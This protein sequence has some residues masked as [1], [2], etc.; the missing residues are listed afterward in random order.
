MNLQERRGTSVSEMLMQTNAVIAFM[1][2]FCFS[3]VNL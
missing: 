1:P 2:R 3:T